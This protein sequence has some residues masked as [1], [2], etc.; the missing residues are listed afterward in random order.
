MTLTFNGNTPENIN[1]N[2]VALSKVTYNGGVVWEKVS[3]PFTFL[4]AAGWNSANENAT[5][6]TFSG[7][8][9]KE[10]G[11]ASSEYYGLVL[12]FRKNQ[13]WALNTVLYLTLFG[14]DYVRTSGNASPYFSIVH[15]DKELT[16]LTYNLVNVNNFSK[17]YGIDL[18]YNAAEHKMPLSYVLTNNV[19]NNNWE[20]FDLCI[21][22]RYNSVEDRFSQFYAKID[23][24]NIPTLTLE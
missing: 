6:T 19:L 14:G 8:M 2:G 22:S 3:G 24:V 20:T 11:V 16:E 21:S 7:Y 5:P 1:W 23:N 4:G 13:E 17:K 10:N 15:N 18:P 9:P 12:R